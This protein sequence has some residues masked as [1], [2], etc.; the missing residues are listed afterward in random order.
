M[1]KLIIFCCA[2]FFLTPLKAQETYLKFEF[3]GLQL[4][5][6]YVGYYEGGKAY[7]L[8]TANVDLKTGQFELPAK[9]L[10]PG[11]YFATTTKGKLLDFVISGADDSISIFLHLA[12]PDSAWA[13]NS[14]ENEAY[15]NFEYQRKKL[16]SAIDAQKN[17]RSMMAKASNRDTNVINGIDRTIMALYQRTDSL[18]LDFVKNHPTNLFAKMYRESLN[19]TIYNTIGYKT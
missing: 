5:V 3:K 16:E 13:K 7:S 15:F 11:L 17:L 9:T 10:K 6:V 4:P 19:S 18:A 8:D 14:P 1:A 2:I 12:H